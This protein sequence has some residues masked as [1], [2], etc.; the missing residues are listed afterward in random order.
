MLIRFTHH[1]NKIFKVRIILKSVGIEENA[2]VI[3]IDPRF[4]AIGQISNLL[5]IQSTGGI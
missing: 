1:G 5:E 2:V 3:I 4:D